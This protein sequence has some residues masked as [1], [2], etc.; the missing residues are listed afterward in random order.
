MK[1][2]HIID[3]VDE[4]LKNVI[5]EYNDLKIKLKGQYSDFQN[6]FFDFIEDEKEKE[7][8]KNDRPIFQI[9]D[10]NGILRVV[11]SYLSKLT[12]QE[13]KLEEVFLGFEMDLIIKE[14]AKYEKIILPINNIKG[15]VHYVKCIRYT[16]STNEHLMLSPDYFAQ[17]KK[18]TKYEHSIFLACL[19]MNVYSN[20]FQLRDDD[21]LKD[22]IEK[23]YEKRMEEEKKKNGENLSKNPKEDIQIENG[24]KNVSIIGKEL[25]LSG[26]HKKLDNTELSKIKDATDRS[27]DNLLKKDQGKNLENLSNII[28]DNIKKDKINLLNAVDLMKKKIETELRKKPEFKKNKIVAKLDTVNLF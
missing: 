27:V 5:E 16:S 25:E 12:I 24:E 6:R 13:F 7:K 20:K 23:E 19:V 11:N 21:E 4:I 15:L 1:T 17:T 28:K 2:N 22:E 8:N 3:S 18:G 9:K 10:Q 26:I 14:R